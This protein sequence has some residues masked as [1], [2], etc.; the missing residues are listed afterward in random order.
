M[1]TS[2]PKVKTR[3]RQKN[4]KVGDL[5]MVAEDT[6]VIVYPDP[7]NSF[8][9]IEIEVGTTGIVLEIGNELKGSFTGEC[10]VLFK[11]GIAAWI[12]KLYIKRISE[13]KEENEK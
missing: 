10:R 5:I 11:E 12:P 6:K 3:R 4:I 2:S 7:I 8:F 1:G 9:P 13:Q